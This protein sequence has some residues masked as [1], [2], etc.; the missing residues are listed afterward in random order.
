MKAEIASQD[1]EVE[2]EGETKA[3]KG[4]G[5]I[6]SEF[7]VDLREGELA[8]EESPAA[9]FF[10][11][12]YDAAKFGSSSA[13]DLIAQWVG[14]AAEDG[15]DSFLSSLIAPQ[16]D[17]AE[18]IS[19]KV[20]SNEKESSLFAN[21]F[22]SDDDESIADKKDDSGKY[23]KIM[24]DWIKLEDWGVP[25]NIKVALSQMFA[26][27]E[28]DSESS[29]VKRTESQ[30][31]ISPKDTRQ[32]LL[33]KKKM[34]QMELRSR[35]KG[36][37]RPIIASGEKITLR[38][39]VKLS[40]DIK[41]TSKSATSE[42]PKVPVTIAATPRKAETQKFTPTSTA[43]PTTKRSTTSSSSQKLRTTE[44]AQAM[45]WSDIFASQSEGE[46]EPLSE[47]GSFEW[48]INEFLTSVGA[49][50]LADHLAALVGK[51]FVTDGEES[52]DVPTRSSGVWSIFSGNGE[53][54][55][56]VKVVKEKD[57]EAYHQEKP[58]DWR[59]GSPEVIRQ[60]QH[61]AFFES[62]KG[63][64][65][66]DK[67]RSGQS[68]TCLLGWYGIDPTFDKWCAE[69]CSE[70]SCSTDACSCGRPSKASQ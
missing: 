20:V 19:K 61:A 55:E 28:G 26:G 25:S 41:A 35:G 23:V 9:A 27:F 64:L 38:R 52:G 60:G 56:P 17:E 46:N 67:K 34:R 54:E 42:K 8:K 30:G 21:F 15:Q 47:S 49:D 13:A 50:S 68:V 70:G 16:R 45:R 58:L 33:L 69:K 37:Q 29:D 1:S 53:T 43:A 66:N 10:E 14:A 36:L 32:I 51:A 18:P 40:T 3:S 6:F 2:E 7:F 62:V 65:D 24:S 11:F 39:A 31:L 5:N 48:K 59:R 22:G 57:P 44:A 12:L 4:P 63:L